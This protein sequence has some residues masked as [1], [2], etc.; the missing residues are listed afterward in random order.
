[1]S[2]LSLL[3]GHFAVC[4]L[5]AAD[6]VPAWASGLFVSITRTAAELSIVCAQEHVPADAKHEPDWRIL[7]VAGPLDFSLTGILAAIATPLAAA[8]ISIFAVSTFDTDYVLVKHASL[9]CAAD[10]LRAAGHAVDLAHA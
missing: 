1:M 2:T 3:P 4:R 8:G 6:P 10:A 7:E 5:S 9:A